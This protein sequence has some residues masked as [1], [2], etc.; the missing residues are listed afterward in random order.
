[1][2]LIC[3]GCGPVSDVLNFDLTVQK[4]DFRLEAA[5]EIPLTGITALSGPSGSGKTTLLRAL[6]GLEPSAD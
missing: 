6:A 2:F 5:A 3:A 4:E 1:M